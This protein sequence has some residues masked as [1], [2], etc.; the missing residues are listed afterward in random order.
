[1]PKKI[2]YSTLFVALIAIIFSINNEALTY[3]TGAPVTSGK[4]YTGS[5]SDGKTCATSGCHTGS[6]VVSETGWII[7]NIPGSGYIPGSTYSFTATATAASVTRFGFQISPQNT[8]GV[9]QGTMVV[10]STTTT[11]IVGTKYITHKT[12]GTPGTGSKAWSFDWKAPPAD[13]VIFYGAFNATNSNGSSSG[14]Q[15]HTSKLTV[16]RDPT[17]GIGGIVYS[18]NNMQIFPNP[19]IE[20]AKVSLN[21]SE[22]GNTKISAYDIQGKLV[23]IFYNDFAAPGH[24]STIIPII[25]T[26]TAGT[27]FIVVER[28]EENYLQKLIVL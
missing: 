3:S 2:L 7:S 4:G 15:I 16:H 18:E 11:Q 23:K 14:D 22:S 9:Y 26:F 27:Y 5:P 21:F 19:A 13:S 28:N 8:S 1:M 12:A 24:F 6:S 20:S 25:G 10:T 17:S